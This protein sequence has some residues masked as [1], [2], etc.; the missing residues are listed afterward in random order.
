MTDQQ[1]AK[2]I[3]QL[4]GELD[5]LKRT[6]GGGG[7][8][9][10]TVTV[11]P[12]ATDGNKVA[13]IKVDSTTIPIFAG[14]PFNIGSDPVKIGMLGADELYAQYKTGSISSD[15][16]S[17]SISGAKALIGIVGMIK[18]PSYWFSLNQFYSSAD[19]ARVQ[20]DIGTV[21]SFTIYKKG[22]FSE[23]K[24]IILYTKAAPSKNRRK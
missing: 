12:A 23:Y 20:Q 17:I 24:M 21:G 10:S 11:T 4:Q 19:F 6:A 14:L 9:G 16:T 15:E 13:D 7:G 8:G 22:S 2:W 18:G 5:S 3:D 1:I